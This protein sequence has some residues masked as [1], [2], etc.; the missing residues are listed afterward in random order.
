MSDKQ[1]DIEKAIALL[2]SACTEHAPGDH[3]WRKCRRCL[4]QADIENESQILATF[5]DHYAEQQSVIDD[6]TAQI[7]DT[8]RW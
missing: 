4:A 8:V 3:N 1:H 7:A 5:L 2:R 6:L